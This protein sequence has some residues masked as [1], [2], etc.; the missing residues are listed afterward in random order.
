MFLFHGTILCWYI[1]TTSILIPVTSLL[2]FLLLYFLLY[3]P[4][5]YIKINFILNWVGFYSHF[6]FLK[7]KKNGFQLLFFLS[8]LSLSKCSLNISFDDGTGAIFIVCWVIT[9]RYE[10]SW[11]PALYLLAFINVS[12]HWGH[13]LFSSFLNWII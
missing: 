12:Y 6:M 13:S 11:S 9:S 2:I 1:T 10:F 3:I 7:K 8:N 4:D 5:F